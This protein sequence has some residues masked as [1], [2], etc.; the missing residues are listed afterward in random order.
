MLRNALI[1]III[2]LLA[3]GIADARLPQVGDQVKIVTALGSIQGGV[4]F[5]GKITDMGDGLICLSCTDGSFPVSFGLGSF[6]FD[7]CIGVGS[8]VSLTWI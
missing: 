6:P 2:M 4:E 7:V 8:I 1:V 5:D 3:L